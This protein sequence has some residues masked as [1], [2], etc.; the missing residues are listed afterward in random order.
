MFTLIHASINLGTQKEKDLAPDPN[1]D[2]GESGAIFNY[3]VGSAVSFPAKS[4]WKS[5]AHG[6][7]PPF[8]CILS[9]SFIY[10]FIASSCICCCIAIEYWV[11]IFVTPSIKH[12]IVPPITAFLKADYGPLLKAN[13]P[14]VKN[15]EIIAL[16][17]SSVY[18]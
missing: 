2:V 9:N 13:T 12:N 4:D 18:R 15:P 10:S 14:P 11:I 8:L 7:A 6:S 3:S 17:G 1:A 5:T 16:N